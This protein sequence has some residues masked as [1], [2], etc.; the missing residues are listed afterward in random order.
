[1]K[2]P[3]MI[4][5]AGKIIAAAD[6]GFHLGVHEIE[7]DFADELVQDGHVEIYD[8][9]TIPLYCLQE[10]TAVARTQEEIDADDVKPEAQPDL[11]SRVTALEQTVNT[12]MADQQAALALLGVCGQEEHASI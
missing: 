12:E 4:D 10:G 11:E 7:A 5:A 8:A 2:I 3:V 1:M 6:A 9:R